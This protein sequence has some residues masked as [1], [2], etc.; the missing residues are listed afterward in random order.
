VARPAGGTSPTAAE[1]SAA[2]IAL[3][4]EATGRDPLNSDAW[5]LLGM[6]Y[7]A[8]AD[9]DGARA[10]LRRALEISPGHGPAT[11][12]L[13]GCLVAGGQA[14]EA[15]ALAATIGKDLDWLRLTCTALAQ[16]ELGHAREAEQALDALVARF[17]QISAYQVGEVHAWRGQ[18][19]LAFEWLERA[20]AQ[21]DMGLGLARI[22]P[23]LRKLH[24]DARWKPFLVKMGVAAD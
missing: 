20:Y 24:G 7:E 15:L 18:P 23:L 12:H 8:A 1:Q 9:L 21:R 13:C 3:Q 5:V 11:M 17:S 10:A 6:A 19:D 16:S 2:R 14:T 22:D 4:R